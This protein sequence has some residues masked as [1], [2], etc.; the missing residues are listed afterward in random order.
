LNNK[1]ALITGGCGDIGGAIASLFSRSGAIV[2][3]N[4][5]LSPAKARQRLDNLGIAPERRLHCKANVC[6]RPAVDAM[7]R[8]I[9]K[10]YGRL[11]IAIGNAGVVK[12]YPF[13]DVPQEEWQREI[14]INLTG[15]FNI[16]QASAR[17]MAKNGC[18]IIL[19]T[20]SWVQD[21]PWPEI[22]PY[23]VSK[24]GLKLLAKGMARE[25]AKYNIRVNL[26]A[27]GIVNAGLAKMQWDNEP[28]YRERAVK[29]IPLKR[30]QEAEEVAQ[31]MLFLCSKEAEYMTG[32]TLLID[33]GCSLFQF[34]A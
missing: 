8:T 24:S 30:R 13:L 20:S 18:G 11:D 26:V 19:F 14:D 15:C 2:V 34:D 23:C 29:I 1:V 4:D 21:I 16:G 9:V 22:T 3:V 5:I 28:G 17:V 25:L 27:P 7:M 31:A 12:G 33:G 6:D 10:K 32:S